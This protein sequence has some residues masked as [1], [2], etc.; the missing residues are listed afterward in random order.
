MRR[1]MTTK[2]FIE[3][4]LAKTRR[5]NRCVHRHE[6]DSHPLCFKKGLVKEPWWKDRKIGYLDI[7]T[8]DLNANFGHIITWCILDGDTGKIIS[9]RLRR[10]DVFRT[11]TFDKRI[12]KDLV[13]EMRHFDVLVVYYGSD[14]RFDL[15][16]IRA[17]CLY[18]NLDFPVD[19]EVFCIDLYSKVKQKL[20]LASRK[21][22]YVTKFLGIKGK[23]EIEPDI[24]KRG[25]VGCSRDVDYIMDHNR[26]DVIITQKTFHRML[27][28]FNMNRSSL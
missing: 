19:R 27:P 3:K 14:Y 10:S 1:L 4:Y 11:G 24:W 9:G 22:K 15:P 21:L 17:R 25:S 7:E 28:Y 13:R 2:T 5:I 26:W 6:Q 12:L 8:S 23:T 16:F 18:W 20:K